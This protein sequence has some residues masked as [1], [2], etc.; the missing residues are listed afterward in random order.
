[1][2]VRVEAEYIA[3]GRDSDNR[4]ANGML[5]RN[6]LREAIGLTSILQF[7]SD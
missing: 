3:E 1:V 7:D 5:F 2:A 4:A 6:D